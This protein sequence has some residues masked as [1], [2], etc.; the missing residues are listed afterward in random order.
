MKVMPYD[1]NRKYDQGLTFIINAIKKR[2]PETEDDFLLLN[3]GARGTGKS[4]L[5]LHIEDEYLQDKSSVDFIGLTHSDFAIALKKAKDSPLPRFCSN[6]EANISKRDTQNTYQKDILDLYYSIRGEQIF[7]IWNNPSL[8]IID[9]KIIDDII[10]G[11]ICIVSKEKNRPRKY[12]Y[13]RKEDVLRIWDK[14]E[15]LSI[16]IL[17]KVASQYAFFQGW[18]KNYDGKLLE[19][20]RAKKQTRMDS[21]IDLFHEKY[22]EQE[23]YISTPKMYNELGV[24]RDCFHK[25]EKQLIDNGIL[26]KE[27]FKVAATGRR[28][29]L[30]TAIAKFQQLAEQN[31]QRMI[32]KT[33]EAR[34]KRSKK[35]QI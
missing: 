21:K 18:F 1:K 3:C 31:K 4:M 24:S 12:Y 10:K 8:D 30:P 32:E 2:I 20:Y 22:A 13:F 35:N 5:T 26:T 33:N 28:I 7:H 14:Y 17:K 19:A 27:D 9:R 11:V 6:D 23:G 15:S 29:F 16:R 25:W 34:A